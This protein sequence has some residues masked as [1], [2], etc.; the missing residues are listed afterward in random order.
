MPLK[1]LCPTAA[2]LHNKTVKGKYRILLKKYVP[3][4][5]QRKARLFKYNSTSITISVPNAPGAL[6]IY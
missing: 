6:L 3:V 2:R 4:L 5:E 1:N